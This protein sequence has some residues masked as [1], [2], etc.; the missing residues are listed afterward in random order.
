M[1]RNTVEKILDWYEEKG[2]DFPWREEDRN[3][4][5][6]LIAEVLLQKTNA[7]SVEKIYEDFLDD[8][9]SIV[10]LANAPEE[11]IKKHL[12]KLGLQERRTKWLMNLSERIMNEHDGS[13]PSTEEELKDLKGIG[14][15]IGNA[16][17]CFGF[18]KKKHV[19]DVNTSKVLGRC[20]SI[21]HEGDLRRNE[22]LKKKANEILP[23]EN[24]K[25]FNWA[26]LDIGSMSCDDSFPTCSDCPLNENCDHYNEENVMVASLND[27]SFSTAKEEGY[28]SYPVSYNYDVKDYLAFYRTAP[29]MSVTHLARIE[30]TTSEELE[31]SGK[32]KLYNFGDDVGDEPVILKIKKLRKLENEIPSAGG[33]GIQG[34]KYTSLKKLD[35]ASTVPDL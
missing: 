15:Y 9:G 3:P 31:P 7:R 13:I 26:L 17:L 29:E 27:Y 22:K 20:F 4:Y 18:G 28:Y 24:I 35:E 32:Y 16:I 14:L 21:D 6:I 34:I 2:R 30:K 5:E 23:D 19:L 12:S 8:F 25:K 10:K 11:E 1:K 33:K